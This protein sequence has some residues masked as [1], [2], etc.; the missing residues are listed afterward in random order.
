LLFTADVLSAAGPT[1]L[2]WIAAPAI[3]RTQVLSDFTPDPDLEDFIISVTNYVGVPETNIP[4][5]RAAS[6]AW[7]LD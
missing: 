7:N 5:P 2:E 3:W 1:T 6:P 4:A